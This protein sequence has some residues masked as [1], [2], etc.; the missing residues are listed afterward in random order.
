[1]VR[2]SMSRFFKGK[3][4]RFSPEVTPGICPYCH[5]N[6]SFVS[7]VN[8]LFRCMSCGEDVEQKINGVIK[9]LPIGSEKIIEEDRGS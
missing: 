8:D 4:I 5:A 2:P 6:S 7:I 3:H 9:Y 1:M